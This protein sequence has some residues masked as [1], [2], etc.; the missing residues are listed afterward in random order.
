MLVSVYCFDINVVL[1]NASSMRKSVYIK[2]LKSS[3]VQHTNEEI[4]LLF[5]VQHLVDTNDHPQ[6]HPLIDGFGQGI[7]SI[8]H[9]L[10]IV[11]HIKI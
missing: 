4:S 3:D 5:C 2:D 10:N 11:E 7:D 6:E 8:V 1:C 9:L